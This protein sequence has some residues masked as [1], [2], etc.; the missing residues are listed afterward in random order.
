MISSLAVH[1]TC[2]RVFIITMTVRN[3]PQLYKKF[4]VDNNYRSYLYIK[5]DNT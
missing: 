1:I 5:T 3:C 2:V 4:Y